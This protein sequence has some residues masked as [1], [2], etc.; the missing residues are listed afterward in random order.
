[1]RFILDP[2]TTYPI[3]K[4]DEWDVK[5][6][7]IY[8]NHPDGEVW[9][10]QPYSFMN[11]MSIHLNPSQ[12]FALGLVVEEDEYEVRHGEDCGY[13]VVHV[14]SKQESAAFY[15]YQSALSQSQALAL[16]NDLCKKLNNKELP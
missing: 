13:E 4:L 5:P 11:A 9:Q 14:Q 8:F 2:A 12:T 7:N 15:Y 1:M 16:A 10:S 3:S 6:H